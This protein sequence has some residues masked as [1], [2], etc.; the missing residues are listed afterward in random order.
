MENIVVI[1]GGL[2]GTAVTWKLAEQGEK[3]LLLEQQGEVYQNGSSFGAARIARS[4]GP[5]KDIFSFVNNR[6]VK[7]VGQL[8]EY[9]NDTR[10]GVHKMTDIYTTSPVN[11]LYKK[12]HQTAIDK[13]AYKKQKK[14]FKK[15][16]GKACLKKFGV[17]LKNDE[18]LVREFRQHSGTINPKALI[19]KLRLGIKRKGGTIKFSTKVT[20]LIKKG[21]LFEVTISNKKTGKTITLQSKKVVVAAGP[22]TPTVLKDL[23]PYFNKIITPK[24]VLLGYYKITTERYQQLSKQAIKGIFEAHPMFSQIGKEYFSMVERIA[25]DGSPIL[26]AGGHQSRKD[27]E[28][29]DKVWNLPAPKKE[30]KWI[31]RKLRQHLQSLDITIKKREL[32]LVDAYNCVYSVTPTNI[33]IV[34]HPKNASGYVDKNIIVIGGMSGIGAKGCLGMVL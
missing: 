5:K 34:T 23:A 26:K 15:A 6:T 19:Q 7:E 30:L 18:I 33:P 31:K 25:E 3:V 28:D 12:K 13:L 21:D 16:T 29:L 1:G 17:Q 22:Y 20:R 4:L 11:Y 10:N 32:E 2:M 8:I 27:I 24:R 14:D 9:L